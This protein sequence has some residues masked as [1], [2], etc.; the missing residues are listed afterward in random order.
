MVES[1]LGIGFVARL[2]LDLSIILL[3][4]ASIVEVVVDYRGLNIDVSLPDRLAT[5]PSSEP[6]TALA[7]GGVVLLVLGVLLTLSPLPGGRLVTGII[8]L[9]AFLFMGGFVISE[10]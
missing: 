7:A 6:A 8:A 1:W 4:L 10:E 2:V 9:I 3:I 5:M